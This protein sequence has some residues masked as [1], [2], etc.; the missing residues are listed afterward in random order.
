MK[1]QDFIQNRSKENFAL[2]D[3]YLNSQMVKVLKT[4][5]FDRHYV[6]A[7]G[8]YLFDEQDNRYLDLLSGFGVF[9][10]GRNHAEIVEALKSTLEAD[11]P[12]LVQ[13]DVSLLAGLLAERLV[14]L[15]PDGLKRVFFANS[16]TETVEA[17]IK[18]SRYATGKSKIIFC[19]GCYHGLSL[20]SL[21]A[22]GDDHYKKG[23][24]P[25]VPDFIEIPF[26][27]LEALEQ[28]LAQGDVAAFITEPIQGHGVWIPDDN[29]LPEAARLTRK[30]GALFITDEIQTGL[31]R[32]GKWWAVEHWS[33][34]PD[35]LCMSKTLSG[36]FIPVGA[37][38][39][40]EWIFD[41]VFNRMDRAVVHGS[42]FGKNNL[43][44]AAGLATL[45]V[46]ESGNLIEHSARTG[47]AIMDALTPLT[48]KYECFKEVRGKGMM[49]ALEFTEPKS[50][51]LKLS[52]K[53]LESANKGLFSQLITVPLFRQHRVLS[54]VAGHGMNI[55]KF[56]PPLI[57]TESDVQ[58]IVT[59][60]SDVVANAHRGPSAVWDFGKTLAFSALRAK[61]HA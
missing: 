52:W 1:I 51:M 26:N 47:A 8:A 39:C 60:V 42:T 36:G 49:I 33:V 14:K 2:H 24:G 16:G 7:E 6:R 50:P 20:G 9:A 46:L 38:V 56:I 25:M 37:L 44:M 27:D 35:I 43:A 34:E 54:Q 10:L 48:E 53:M 3:K 21:S 55:V 61:L 31:G 32:T 45:E 17:A 15:T 29:Y 12:N 57:L 41:R 19:H 30:Y 11:L 22:T 18:F 58:W 4:I 40:K 13:L 5:D 23:F 59:A 28:V